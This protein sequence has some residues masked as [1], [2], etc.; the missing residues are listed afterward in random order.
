MLSLAL[1]GFAYSPFAAQAAP[2]ATDASPCAGGAVDTALA[3]EMASVGIMYNLAEHPKSVRAV[4]ARLLDDALNKSKAHTEACKDCS[5]TE[6]TRVLY[7]VGPTKFLPDAEQQQICRTLD[8]QTAAKPFTW[9]DRKFKTLPEVN[10]WIRAFSEGRGEEG[11]ALYAKCSANC[12][13][14]Y[15]FEISPEGEQMRLSTR[16][17][18]GLARDAN[19]DQYEVATALRTSCKPGAAKP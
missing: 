10:D 4:A 12:S 14:R 5:K 7:R 3:S 17:H 18:C 6:T 11:K 1:A 8:Q 13:P 19:D 9:P 16:V 2:A 15:E